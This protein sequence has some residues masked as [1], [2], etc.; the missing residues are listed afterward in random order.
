V[1]LNFTFIPGKEKRKL[2][3][4]KTLE[5]K[6][7]HPHQNQLILRTVTGSAYSSPSKCA[8]G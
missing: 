6:Y 7:I 5:V 3:K 1:K 8:T 2:T 4:T